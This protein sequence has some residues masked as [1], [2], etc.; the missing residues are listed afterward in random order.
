MDLAYFAL[1]MVDLAGLVS[2]RVVVSTV[3]EADF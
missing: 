1:A 3:L 2:W